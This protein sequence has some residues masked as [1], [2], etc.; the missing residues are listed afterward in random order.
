M[1]DIDSEWWLRTKLYDKRDYFY[2]SIVNFP[3]IRSNIPET[4][5]Y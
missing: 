3:F 1:L 5:A 4:P 2:F